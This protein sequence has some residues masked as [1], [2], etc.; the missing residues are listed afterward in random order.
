MNKEALKC[1]AK[2]NERY[3]AV[4]KNDPA[5][6]E[7]KK[8]KPNRTKIASLR[9]SM[10]ALLNKRDEL[11]SKLLSIYNGTEVNFDGTSVNQKWRQVKSDEAEKCINR[12]KKL[13]K[14][15]SRLPASNSEKQKLYSLVNENVDASST[16]ALSKYRI[17]NN[18]YV[19]KFEKKQLSKDIKNCEKIIKDN[20]EEIKRA[21]KRIKKRG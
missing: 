20:N 8:K 4:I 7:T 12:N 14:E 15:I 1:E 21:I 17:K 9:T 3:Y 10:M 19:E 5:V 16:K 2:D 13:A 6:M 18:D 11:N